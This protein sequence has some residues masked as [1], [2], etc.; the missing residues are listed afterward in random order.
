MATNLTQ[1]QVKELIKQHEE[2]AAR[3]FEL[4]K[5][6]RK[7]KKQWKAHAMGTATK[8]KYCEMRGADQPPCD[9]K[10]YLCGPGRDTKKHGCCCLG[11]A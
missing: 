4:A 2:N 1:T 7:L 6:H 8:P 10:W 3:L 11:P 9:A 5:Y